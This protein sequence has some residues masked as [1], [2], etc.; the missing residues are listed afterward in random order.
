[1]AGW[2]KA[3]TAPAIIRSA[4]RITLAG[5]H[6]GKRPFARDSKAR[7]I[8]TASVRRYSTI[9]DP[10]IRLVLTISLLAVVLR[11]SQECFFEACAGDLKAGKSRVPRQQL[12]HDRLGLDGVNLDRLAIFFRIGHAANLPN[13]GNAQAGDAANT[14]AAGL[15]LNLRRSS[16]GDNLALIEDGDEFG[17]RVGLLEIMSC[18]QHS[19]AAVDHTANL[20]PQ[21]AAGF[22]VETDRGA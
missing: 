5:S 14:L 19:L 22:D 1:M 8:P 7:G 12:A 10:S 20:I 13:A 17:G 18:E 6:Q 2:T 15:R 11:Q 9:V 3:M 21:H 16:V 4:P